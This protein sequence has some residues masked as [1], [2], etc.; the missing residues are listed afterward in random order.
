ME[1]ENNFLIEIQISNENTGLIKKVP[2]NQLD[3]EIKQIIKDLQ[4]WLEE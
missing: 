4:D 2:I 3:E 1:S